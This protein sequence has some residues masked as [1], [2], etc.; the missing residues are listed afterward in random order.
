MR[1]WGRGSEV[2]Q[3]CVG[4]CGVCTMK[5]LP[6]RRFRLYV[7]GWGVALTASILSVLYFASRDC[8]AI[9]R[10]AASAARCHD[11]PVCSA[12]IVQ[13]VQSWWFAARSYIC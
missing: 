2:G 6:A 10:G 7:Y 1:L 11:L 5:V 9:S 4:W 8:I 12:A 13:P 3:V